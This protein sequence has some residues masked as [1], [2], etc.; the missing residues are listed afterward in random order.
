[1]K[2]RFWGVRG[3][4]AV[5]GPQYVRYGGNTS[6][7]EV[8]TDNGTHIIFDAGSGLRRLGDR[9]LE[10]AN[11]PLRAHLFLTHTH[12]DH[13][14]GLPYFRPGD[15]PAN[16][17]LV[18]GALGLQRPL[19]D[20]LRRQR[21]HACG[22][23]GTIVD[24]PGLRLR[25]IDEGTYQVD[26]VEVTAQYL[27][28]TSLTIGYRLV[29]G[30]VTV[31]YSSDHEPFGRTIWRPE[32]AGRRPTAADA[33]HEGDR[34]HVELARDADL[35]IHDAQYT[36]EEYPKKIGW[37]HSTVDYATEVALAAESRVLM[38]YHHDTT[39][40]DDQIDRLAVECQDRARALGG[41]LDLAAAFEGLELTLA[42]GRGE[43]QA[44]HLGIRPQ[45]GL[46]K[47]ILIA[48]DSPVLLGQLEDLLKLD[49][50]E[51]LRAADGEMAV[52]LALKERPDMLILDLMMP[53]MDG[54]A[55]CKALR[56]R[57]ET[58][59]LPIIVLTALED[60]E[61]TQRGFK[62]GV[63]DYLLKPLVP[64]QLRARVRQWLLRTNGNS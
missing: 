33:V 38:L 7:V 32:S 31:V 22:T 47:R 4:V 55:V 5:S 6:C 36:T 39:H 10:Q 40:P 28:H 26:D 37:G 50:Y 43:T 27:N 59:S 1:V 60:A 54:F 46:S 41:R 19:A 29:V 25:D 62:A 30:G 35:L 49:G 52:T 44:P 23:D 18:Y 8:E 11:G 2:V 45:V 64:P 13:I 20:L 9:L 63:N 34:L 61:D 58:R 24:A 16:E 21:E 53:K 42:E 14:Q 17:I 12:W 51:V 56:A 48:D 15:D 57:P 3:S